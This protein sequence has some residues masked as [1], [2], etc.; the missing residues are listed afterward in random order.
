[1]T[2]DNNT[3]HED[4]LPQN[5]ESSES[6]DPAAA[7]DALR[8]TVEKHAVDLNAEMTVI[9]KA[10]EIAF[11]RLETFQ[12]P[13]DYRKDIGRMLE[14]IESL[15]QAQKDFSELPLHKN[16]PEHYARIMERS[17]ESVVQT[18]TQQLEQRSRDL[19]RA[20][21]DIAS[22]ARSARTRKSQNIRMWIAGGVG[23]ALGVGTLLLLPRLW[24]LVERLMETLN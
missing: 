23:F 4:G 6:N 20:A 17:G 18:A 10:V 1:M 5:N 9:R 7:F 22:Y 15:A 24:P 8:N 19:E 12:Q 16:G 21:R 11:E 14:F 3:A 13:I 2:D